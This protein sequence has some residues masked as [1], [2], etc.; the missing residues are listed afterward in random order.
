MGKC[1]ELLSGKKIFH[2]RMQNYSLEGVTCENSVYLPD[3]VHIVIAV[4]GAPSKL[5]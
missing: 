2:M 1:C 4:K 5:I 3:G